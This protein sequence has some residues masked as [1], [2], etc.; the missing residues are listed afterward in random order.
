MLQLD[1]VLLIR[2]LGLGDGF[3]LIKEFNDARI[4]HQFLAKFP[5]ASV[6]QTFELTILDEADQVVQIDRIVRDSG[7]TFCIDGGQGIDF[8]PKGL[9]VDSVSPENRRLHVAGNEGLVEVPDAGD[10][11]LA[12][13]SLF[14]HCRSDSTVVSSSINCNAFQNYGKDSRYRTFP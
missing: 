12:V 4:E 13:E 2:G 11:V 7:A 5:Q 10:D 14:R 1:V 3:Q 9:L 8:L 6:G